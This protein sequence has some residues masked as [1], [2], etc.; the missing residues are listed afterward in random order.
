[1]GNPSDPTNNTTLDPSP[2]ALSETGLDSIPLDITAAMVE[3]GQEPEITVRTLLK[4][5]GAAKRGSR[6]VEWIRSELLRRGL[7]TEPDFAGIWIDAPIR[8]KKLQAQPL[9]SSNLPESS[10]PPTPTDPGTLVPMAAAEQ[11]Q[12]IPQ[13][14]QLQKTTDPIRR[15]SLL[16]AA[17]QP[18]VSVTPG[19][20]L[21][22]ATTIMML[23]D[24]SQLPVL[25]S[26]FTCKGVVTWQSIA[27]A[28]A[29]GNTCT[30]VNECLVP[31]QEV[32]WNMDLLEAIPKIVESGFA[33]VRG[34]NNKFQGI[35][36]VVDLSLQFKDLSEPFLLLEQIE[37]LLRAKIRKC[38]DLEKIQQARH[39]ND[40][41][42]DVNDVS[43][44]SFGEYVRLLESA[45]A[46]PALGFSFERVS[47]LA[48]LK[49]VLE[50]RNEVMHFAPDPLAADDIALLKN[51][52]SFLKRAVT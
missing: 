20:P 42:R 37:N 46:W 1:M 19:T 40:T 17:N 23:N 44:L 49:E 29:L 45:D 25:Q 31:T 16:S 24:F 18:V 52:A 6:V 28:A 47:F 43:D 39:S 22:K 38:F 21:N 41:L 33:L 34:Q 51:F 10:Q 48:K 4:Y 30:S 9:T 50:L 32:S 7:V 12:P 11:V 8:I 3:H 26:E 27:T 14:Q 2:D 5:F 36:T 35:V 13:L 15:I